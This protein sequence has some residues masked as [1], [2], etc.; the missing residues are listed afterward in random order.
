MTDP[1]NDDP[2]LN[3]L[4]ARLLR[5]KQSVRATFRLPD[6]MIDLLKVAAV[7]LGVKQKS[8]IDQLVEDQDILDQIAREDQLPEHQQIQR[9]QKTFVLSRKALATL[10]AVSEA[11]G[12][13]RDV[14]VERSIQRLVPFVDGEQ[15]KHRKRRRLIKEVEVYLKQGKKLLNEAD[16]LLDR[17]DTFRG[18]LEKM[19]SHTERNVEDLRKFVKEKKT[20][21]Y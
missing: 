9:R 1:P 2:K 8:L 20:L 12:I 10:D 7:H 11:Y 13:S 5:G 16:K 18:K 17:E 19:V 14:L 15:E 6:Q 21:L 3:Q 4:N